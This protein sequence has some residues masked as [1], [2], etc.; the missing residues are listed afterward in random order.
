MTVTV[1]SRHADSPRPA[2]PAG[3]RDGVVPGALVI[4]R[5]A[6]EWRLDPASEVL[7]AGK[8]AT[9]LAAPHARIRVYRLC[10]SRS[11]TSS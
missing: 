3:A 8:A 7:T 9:P 5:N 6:L 2:G 4:A 1:H 11:R 10:S